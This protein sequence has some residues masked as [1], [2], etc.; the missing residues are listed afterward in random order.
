MLDEV[1]T[2]LRLPAL[3]AEDAGASTFTPGTVPHVPAPARSRLPPPLHLSEQA[4]RAGAVPLGLPSPA[5]SASARSPPATTVSS[6]TTA[7]GGPGPIAIAASAQQHNFAQVPS[8]TPPACGCGA[9]EPGTSSWTST[10]PQASAIW[11]P[12][13][14]AI[15]IKREES[16]RLVWA[17]VSLVGAFCAR[18]TA[19]GEEGIELTLLEAGNVSVLVHPC[20]IPF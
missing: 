11:D 9:P 14:N 7:V 6:A 20:A 8:P 15:Q 4:L 1:L 3:D 13:W 19:R 2:A 5:S 18:C 16:R 10:Q 12:S 17:A